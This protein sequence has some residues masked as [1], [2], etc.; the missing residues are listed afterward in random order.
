MPCPTTAGWCPCSAGCRAAGISSYR[1]EWLARDIVAEVV[2][3][4][5][6]VP[7]G[8][9]HAELAGLPPITRLHTSDPGA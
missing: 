4:T 5:L 3:T 2:L 9:A 7:Q 8:M 1:R 6:L